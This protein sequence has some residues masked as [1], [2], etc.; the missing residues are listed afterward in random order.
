M[1]SLFEP[2]VCYIHSLPPDRTTIPKPV[3]VLDLQSTFGVLDAIDKAK[4][5]VIIRIIWGFP[6]IGVPLNHP[7]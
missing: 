3:L 7:F 1:E 2:V 5:G 4:G 6:K